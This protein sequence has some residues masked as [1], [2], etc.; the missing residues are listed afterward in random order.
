MKCIFASATWL[1]GAEKACQRCLCA[2]FF[3][4]LFGM[5]FKLDMHF[6][7]RRANIQPDINYCCSSFSLILDYQDLFLI[8]WI[9][10]QGILLL[11]FVPWKKQVV[12]L[13]KM[14]QHAMGLH[15]KEYY[16]RTILGDNFTW[17]LKLV[18]CPQNLMSLFYTLIHFLV[19]Y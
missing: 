16:V 2:F 9:E 8:S 15:S 19:S 18:I 17:V 13:F 4:F 11:Q 1:A 10:G 7:N 3:F 5:L 6:R 14:F 12:W